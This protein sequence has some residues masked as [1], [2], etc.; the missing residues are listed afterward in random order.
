MKFRISPPVSV[1]LGLFIM[2]FIFTAMLTTPGYNM[3][4]Q[5][6]SDLGVSGIPAII[7]NIGVIVGGI[8][9]LSFFINLR[10]FIGDSV[11]SKPGIIIG[12]ISSLCLIGVGIFPVNINTVHII[13]AVSFFIVIE[14]SIAVI[15]AHILLFS[16]LPKSY[17]LIGFVVVAIDAVFLLGFSSP[18][19]QKFVSFGLLVWFL[20][21]NIQMSI[22]EHVNTDSGKM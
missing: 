14:L 22:R 20:F 2:S 11:L 21:F 6:L 5:Y 19:V 8:L 3:A 12:I 16:K 18:T 15:S 17:G 1:I 13:F 4:Y 7:F 10:G 9:L